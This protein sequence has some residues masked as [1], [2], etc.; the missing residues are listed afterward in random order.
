M[1]A[2]EIVAFEGAGS[3]CFGFDTPQTAGAT[4]PPLTSA[5]EP[6]PACRRHLPGGRQR[7]QRIACDTVAVSLGLTPLMVWCA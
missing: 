2:G 6:I 7:E 3:T 1:V 5:N 4:Q